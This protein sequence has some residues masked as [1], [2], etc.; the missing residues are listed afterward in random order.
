MAGFTW[1]HKHTAFKKLRS[2]DDS[3]KGWSDRSA[4]LTSS[5]LA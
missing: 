4:A 1:W 3:S 5:Q 2:M